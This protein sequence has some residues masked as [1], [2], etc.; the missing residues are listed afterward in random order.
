MRAS[1]LNLVLAVS[2]L[3]T[4]CAHAY[5]YTPPSSTQNI[6]KSV[7]INEP[8]DKVWSRLIP[9]LSQSFFVINNLDKES[10]LIN[11]SYSGDP[12]L[13]IDCG[14]IY[15]LVDNLAGKRVYQFPAAKAYQEFEVW[16]DVPTPVR[17]KMVLDGRINIV[18]EQ[19]T[20]EQTRVSVHVRY[21]VE[22]RVSMLT[23]VVTGYST[24]AIWRDSTDSTAF[25]SGERGT[26]EGGTECKCNGELERQIIALLGTK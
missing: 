10:G 26:L 5:R 8:K 23:S 2:V 13:F 20:A 7:T 24:Q 19:A 22:K 6:Q 17:R 14:E 3:I 11:I 16:T 15:S 12:E 21:A 9:A 18:V 25:N 1:V 4:G